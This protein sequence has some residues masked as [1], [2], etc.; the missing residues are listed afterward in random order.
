MT[1]FLSITN[2]ARFTKKL[3]MHKRIVVIVQRANS[4]KIFH[5]CE[6]FPRWIRIKLYERLS[7]NNYSRISSVTHIVSY[8]YI[9]LI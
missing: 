2:F 5:I 7:N 8:I 6:K 3:F 4:Q 1:R 9:F